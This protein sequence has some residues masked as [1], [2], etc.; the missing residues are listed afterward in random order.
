[1]IGAKPPHLLSQKE[2]EKETRLEDLFI[3]L[4]IPEEQVQQQ[5]RVGDYI[6]FDQAAQLLAGGSCLAGKA[7][8]NRAGVAALVVCAREL[9]RVRHQA[10]L[11]LVATVQEEVGVR[12]R[13]PPPTA[14]LPMQ[15]WPWMSPTARRRASA[16]AK[17]LPWARAL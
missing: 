9:E 7:L 15:R 8:D 12:G 1:M 6:T 5:V 4:G 14:W 10:D 3:D 13:L 2:L 16:A 11:Y 17:P